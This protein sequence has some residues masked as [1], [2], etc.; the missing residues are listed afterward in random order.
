M[1]SFRYEEEYRKVK[2]SI[3][4]QEKIIKN[5]KLFDYLEEHTG[6]NMTVDP[7]FST[8]ILYHFLKS[9]V[10]LIEYFFILFLV[11]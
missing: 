1:N 5:K 3:L 4:V 6:I 9:Q 7:S 10:C 11:L 8:Y 2:N